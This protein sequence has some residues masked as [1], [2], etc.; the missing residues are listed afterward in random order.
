V[1]GSPYFPDQRNQKVTRSLPCPHIHSYTLVFFLVV[2][3]SFSN[4]HLALIRVI[5]LLIV[6]KTHFRY[7][8]FSSAGGATSSGYA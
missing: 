3:L 5:F 6:D 4:F 7:L 8:A 2:A 1:L